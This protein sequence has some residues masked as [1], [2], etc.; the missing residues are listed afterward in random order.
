MIVLIS[1]FMES[2]SDAFTGS[3]SAPDNSFSVSRDF[4]NSTWKLLSLE[5]LGDFY[6]DRGQKNKAKDIYSQA[7]KIENIPDLF[8]K[9]IEKKNKSTN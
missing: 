6:L 9:E 7:L 8:K 4:K 1:R 5:I 3:V 2:S